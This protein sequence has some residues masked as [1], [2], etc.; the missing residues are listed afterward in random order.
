MQRPVLPAFFLVLVVVAAPSALGQTAPTAPVQESP[1]ATEA[2][3]ASDTWLG[4]W[5]GDAV[6][7]GVQIV[8]LVPAGPA[9][10]A[11]LLAGDILLEANGR[12]LAG[13]ADLS[14]VLDGMKP[15]D[16][17]RLVVL[18]DAR[19]L[20]RE[21]LVGSRQRA[22]PVLAAPP[23]VPS[24]PT[25]P[26]TAYARL[27]SMGRGGRIGLT[28]ADATP[29]LRRHYGAPEEAG[30][31]VTRVV[32]GMPAERAGLRVGDV[33]VTVGSET[34]EDSTRLRSVLLRWNGTEALDARIV[35]G[36]KAEVVRIPAT[37]PSAVGLGLVGER[38]A[39][40]ATERRIRLEIEQL[41]RRLRELRRELERLQQQ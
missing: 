33:I 17:L 5:M 21:V 15:G 28:V 12:A 22:Y 38:Q 20:E 31:L 39:R 30:V 13:Q 41:E 7:G 34:I 23:A 36:G 37:V 32:S 16:S 1:A 9:Q 26:A 3:R 29:D 40:E 25:A 19:S 14:G 24:A 35:R 11:G 6:D 2:D 4:V 27:E 8:A 10:R 18:R